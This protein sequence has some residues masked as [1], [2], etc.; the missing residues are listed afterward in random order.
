MRPLVHYFN[1]I[2][3]LR[4]V[5]LLISPF[6][7]SS[8]LLKK[9]SRRLPRASHL[10]AA[11]VAYR[12][13]ISSEWGKDSHPHFNDNPSCRMHSSFSSSSPTSS[14][15]HTHPHIS[16][17]LD[18]YISFVYP[19]VKSGGG[20]GRLQIRPA[21]V[22]IWREQP[23]ALP[24]VSPSHRSLISLSLSLVMGWLAIAAVASCVYSISWSRLWQLVKLF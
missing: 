18:S 15:P 5:L 16:I 24:S 9:V 22:H 17:C 20:G 12:N 6:S 19:S 23:Q 1:C 14:P 21:H 2:I 7:S 3:R 4:F 8:S 10:A 13:W 11:R